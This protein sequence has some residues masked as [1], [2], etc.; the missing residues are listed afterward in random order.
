MIVL[1]VAFTVPLDPLYLN[2][3]KPDDSPINQRDE[4][5]TSDIHT[6]SYYCER[7]QLHRLP[8]ISTAGKFRSFLNVEA[9]NGT[10]A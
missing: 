8:M 10:S 2:A 7:L 6:C 1:S 3:R 4:M 9:G 5:M